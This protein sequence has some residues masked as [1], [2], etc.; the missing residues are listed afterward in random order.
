MKM[1]KKIFSL[2]FSLIVL[3]TTPSFSQGPGEPYFPETANGAHN[4]YFQYQSLRWQN[5]V[6]VTYNEVYISY[7][8]LKVV[9]MDQ[10][11]LYI[12]GYPTTVFDSIRI[13]LQLY[14]PT[15]YF[16][17]V[18]EYNSTGFTQGDVWHFTTTRDD[19]DFSQLDDFSFGL[20]R[21][22]ISNVGGCGWQIGESPNYTLPVP[23]TSALLRADKNLCG[24]NINATATFQLVNNMQYMWFAQLEFNSDWKA[25]NPSDV[26]KVEMTSNNGNTW[27]TIWEKIGINDRNNHISVILFDGN[28][29]SINNVQV[30]FKTLQSGIDSWWAIDNIVISARTDLLSH[31]HAFITNVRTNY[32]NQPKMIV[33]F[34]IALPLPYLRI[35]RKTGIPLEPNN[36]EILASFSS[37]HIYN[38][39]ID[40]TVTESTIYTYRVGVREGNG[41]YTYSNEE[42]GYV[43]PPI[44][45]ELQSFTAEVIE[46][47]VQLF[48]LTATETNNSGFEIQRTSPLPSPYQGEGGEAGRGWET[49]GFVP[50][51]GTTTEVHHYSFVDEGLQSG[52][53]QY[54]LKQIDFDGS[55][56]Y[57]NIIEVT[58][59][60]PTK[61]ALEQNYPNPFNPTTKIKFT[62]PSVETHRDASLQVTLKVYDVLG[63]EVATL[64]NEVKQPGTYEVEFNIASHSGNVRNLKSGIY[65]YQ[66]KAGSFVET[67]KM[68]LMK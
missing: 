12:S 26:A 47:N 16:W 23:S 58:I 48:W 49:V 64:V 38:T 42:T 46:N 59:D 7:D 30:R 4:A 60:A 17:C 18:V 40:S 9:N 51:F 65:F 24:N 66:L 43:F 6:D 35:E 27:T 52:N 37:I 39:F 28:T 36:Y 33:N 19:I 22:T 67:K 62:I 44:P 56:E 54:R 45:V 34:Q 14:F 13:N 11:V 3:L 8:S 68:V 21:W 5:P 63:N 25:E 10:S 29:G 61:F 31:F 53:Y 2:C 50:G 20:G 57:S 55:F 1:K 15:R 32:S 41:W